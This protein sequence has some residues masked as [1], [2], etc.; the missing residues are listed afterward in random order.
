MKEEN[1][2]KAI[3]AYIGFGA[4]L[5]DAKETILEAARQLGS[6]R[7]V[8]ECRLSSFYRTAPVDAEGPDFTNAVARIVTCLPPEKLL[9]TTQAIE[10]A[11]G[12]VRPAG[13]HNAPRTIDLDI[14]LYGDRAISEP[15]RL[16][17]PHPR[18]HERAFVLV[19]LTELDSEAV[20]PGRGRA[21][22]FLAS[23]ADQRLEKLPGDA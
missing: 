6:A 19:P 10:N 12:R 14:E 11:L 2:T 8:C 16:V 9:E 23:V 13:V 20:I 22:D 18:M 15:P 3:T 1:C 7:G 21:A 17:V 5:G 4:N